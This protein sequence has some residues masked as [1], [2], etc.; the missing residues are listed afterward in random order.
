[1]GVVWFY[2]FIISY[3]PLK[4]AAWAFGWRIRLDNHERKH[5]ESKRYAIRDI[6]LGTTILAVTL[7]IGKQFIPGKLPDW[8][9]V[10]IES[11]LSDPSF[12][13]AFLIFSVVSLLVKLPCIWI[14][15]A[16]A[17]TSVLSLSIM[18]IFCSGVFGLIELGVLILVLG[19]PG[20]E[21]AE[22]LLALT[23]GHASMAATMIAVLYGLRRFGYRM[24]RKN[25]FRLIPR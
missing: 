2:G 10:L 19:P 4:S 21:L 3:I 5:D 25:E 23:L 17:E 8:S 7:A 13:T 22:V 6:M 15:L 11:G 20:S 16:A 18:W 14:A 1:M 9:E 24:C 12:L